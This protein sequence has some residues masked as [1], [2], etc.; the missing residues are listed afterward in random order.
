MNLIT[1]IEIPS[2]GPLGEHILVVP[3]EIYLLPHI[4]EKP[5]SDLCSKVVA[6]VEKVRPEDSDVKLHDH[7]RPILAQCVVEARTYI[8]ISNIN[9]SNNSYN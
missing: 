2:N 3:Y 1:I 8:Y 5:I 9:P 7:A 4:A 6:S